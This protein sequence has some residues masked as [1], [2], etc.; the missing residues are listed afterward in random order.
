M[1]FN[2]KNYFIC[3]LITTFLIGVRVVD[4]YFVETARLKSFDYY[5]R[6]QE[7]VEAEEIAIIE[8]DD[9]T[10]TDTQRC[11]LCST[12]GISHCSQIQRSAVCYNL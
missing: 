12:T 2:K 1:S 4:P 11:Y 9:P 7:K 5:Q 10:A 3:L 6:N 8:I